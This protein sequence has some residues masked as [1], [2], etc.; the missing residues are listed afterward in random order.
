M[1]VKLSKALGRSLLRYGCLEAGG[2][3]ANGLPVPL[4]MAEGAVRLMEADLRLYG[5]RLFRSARGTI[6]RLHRAINLRER[7]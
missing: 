6:R 1:D 5:P 2:R 3:A 4:A 7:T